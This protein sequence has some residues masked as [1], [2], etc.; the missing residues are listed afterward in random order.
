MYTEKTRSRKGIINNDLHFLGAFL[1]PY[2]FSMLV[3]G[4]P[5]FFLEVAVGQYIGKGGMSVVGQLAPM[6]KGVGYSAMMMVFL[7]NV[8][9]IIV[10]TWT[11]FYLF[12]SFT[13]FPSL[14][15]SDCSKGGNANTITRPNSLI[16]T[17]TCNNA[18]VMDG[19]YLMQTHQLTDSHTPIPPI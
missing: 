10:V 3:C 4:I 9:Y 5:L 12:N 11:L 1:I 15:W 14:P 6:F 18:M 8:Y 13:D 7:E 2:F 17:I 19:K 16:D